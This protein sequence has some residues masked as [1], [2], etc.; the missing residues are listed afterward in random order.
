M[1]TK[2]VGQAQRKAVKLFTESYERKR[3]PVILDCDPG[4]D[5]AFAMIMAAF[6]PERLELLGISTVSGNQSLENT[7]MNALRILHACGLSERSIPVAKG[8]SAPLLHPEWL[9]IGVTSGQQIVTDKS[10]EEEQLSSFPSYPVQVHGE[11]GM[12]GGDF[13][14][15]VMSKVDERKA[16][17]M[18]ADIISKY[19]PDE[20]VV[21]MGTGP[22]TNIALFLTLYPQLG[23]NINIVIMGGTFER[24]NIHPTAEF[25]ILHD[26]EAAHIVFNCGVPVTMIPLD[27]TH[28]VLVT[29][30]ILNKILS[31]KTAFAKNMGGLLEF[32]RSSYKKTFGFSSP[33]LHDPCAVA[34]VLEPSR[35]VTQWIRVD[36]ELSSGYCRGQT[37]GDFYG[38][39]L[40]KPKNVCVAMK[41]DIDWFW[42]IMLQS[43]E[44]ANQQ[45]PLNVEKH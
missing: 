21:L 36:V 30:D 32:F 28:Q 35:F 5:D 37:V 42:N 33:P 41:V 23:K 24:G 2:A 38:H 3:I 25:N 20:P 6:N 26:P 29:E 9:D 11:T 40:R 18:M 12:D 31:M 10:T 4:H 7:T 17:N 16:W 43:L 39:L 15:T 44:R 14:L 8:A 13:P 34:Y 22:L 1:N 27:L 19:S 45:S